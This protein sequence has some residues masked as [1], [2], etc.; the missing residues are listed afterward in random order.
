MIRRDL[1]HTSFLDLV[2]SEALL[3]RVTAA[4]SSE[5]STTCVKAVDV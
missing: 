1:D 4:V 2:V 3:G 5:V